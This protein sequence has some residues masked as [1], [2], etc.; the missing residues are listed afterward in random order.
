MA[1]VTGTLKDF[2]L[3]P[4]TSYQPQITF[5]PSSATGKNGELYAARPIT[6]VPNSAGSFIVDLLPTED[7]VTAVWYE[8]KIQWLDSDGGY[9]AVDFVNSK[10]FVPR[11]GGAI[12]ALI[13]FPVNPALV[14]ISLSPPKAGNV[15]PGTWWM[16]S[17]PND[18][19]DPANTGILYEWSS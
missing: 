18:I 12:G 13:E 7:A 14:Y 11:A 5:T 1:V 3:A 4:L 6:V 19:N 16:H 8:V 10:L 2:G 17:N 9:A 15:P